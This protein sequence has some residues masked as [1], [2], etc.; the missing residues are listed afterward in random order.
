MTS[1]PSIM[2]A[3]IRSSVAIYDTGCIAGMSDA[4]ETKYTVGVDKSHVLKLMELLIRRDE[5]GLVNESDI[6]IQYAQGYVNGYA[7]ITS[8]VMA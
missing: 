8:G 2:Q 4:R 6:H 5:L 1:Q 3:F 7:A